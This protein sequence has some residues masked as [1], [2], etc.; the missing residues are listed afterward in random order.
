[1]TGLLERV[2]S[3]QP[4]DNAV[5]PKGSIPSY[6]RYI[7]N[8]Q[9]LKADVNGFFSALVVVT[10]NDIKPE[11]TANQQKLATGIIDNCLPG[12]A[13]FANRK[14]RP[15]YNFWPTDTPQIFPNSGFLNLFDKSK[16]LPDDLD[17]TVLIL[18]AQ[19]ASDS[20]AR[21]VHSIMQNFTNRPEKQVTNTFDEYRDIPAYSTWFGV[22]MPVDF[23]LCVL[24]NVLYFVQKKDLHWSGADSASLELITRMIADRKHITDP[25][26]VS[27]SYARLPNILYHVSRLMAVKPIPELEKLKP[28][29]ILDAQDA[30]AGSTNFM[31]QVILGTALMRWGVMP[32][33]KV[34]DNA[35]SLQSMV[36]SDDFSFF[37]ATMGLILPS[38]WKKILHKPTTFYYHS[39]A[40][41]NVLLLENLAWRKRLMK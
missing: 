29:L 5:F 6:R 7:L 10:L 35:N 8:N 24:T 27:G 4:T 11:L 22:K 28:Q 12:F 31:D 37:I 3:L 14:G 26:F 25:E 17:D 16:Q 2:I 13:K 30:L 39:P 34:I 18:L 40:Y 15:T 19:N 32:P 1:M 9:W 20:I 23:D 21:Q 41:N 38:K 33:V 36:E